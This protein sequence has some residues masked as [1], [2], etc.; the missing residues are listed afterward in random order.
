MAKN[1]VVSP[2]MDEVEY[3]QVRHDLTFVVIL[4]IIFFALLIGLYFYNRSTGAL[5]SFFNHLLKF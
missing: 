5:D 1:N 4:N 2:Q 3:R